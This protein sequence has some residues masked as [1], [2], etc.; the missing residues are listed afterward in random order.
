MDG[1]GVGRAVANALI[2]NL[3]LLNAKERDHLMRFAYLG[4]GDTDYSGA[5]KFLS[6]ECDE[7][8]RVHAVDMGLTDSAKCVFAG[9]DYHLDWL[10]AALLAARASVDLK[11][12][13]SF[14]P[15]AM[16][17]HAGVP[18]VKSLHTDFRPVTGSQEDVDLLVVYD[19]GQKLAMLFIEAKGSAA[20]DRVQLARKLIRLDRILVKSGMGRPEQRGVVFRLILAAP[21]PPKF[22]CCLTHTRNLPEAVPGEPDTYGAMRDALDNHPSRIG[23]GLYF[24]KLSQFPSG[25]HAVKRIHSGKAGPTGKRTASDG[26]TQWEVRKRAGARKR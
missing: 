23:V 7:I 10:F 16:A 4:E 26:Y 21:T 17:A 14:S 11:E 25:L 15:V 5:S 19:D 6:D 8:L 2:G 13:A 12:G 9:M 1:D 20:F 22:N 18:G 3:K 24:L